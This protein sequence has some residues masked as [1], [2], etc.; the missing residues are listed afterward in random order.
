VEAHLLSCRR[1]PKGRID[2][3]LQIPSLASRAWRGEFCFGVAAELGGLDTFGKRH[4]WPTLTCLHS[5]H[6]LTGRWTD[7]LSGFPPMA[8]MLSGNVARADARGRSL[9]SWRAVVQMLWL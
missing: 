6:V 7:L 9:E 4:W 1:A 2:D 5:V 8:D 3:A